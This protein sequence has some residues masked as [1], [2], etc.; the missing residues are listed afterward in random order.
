MSLSTIKQW[1]DLISNNSSRLEKEK[2]IK[3]AL[4][5]E[6]F[7]EKIIYYTYNP[8]LI[9]HT[10]RVNFIKL[11]EDQ[12][13]Q[14]LNN[15]DNIFNVL[16]YLNNKTGASNEDIKLLSYVSSYDNDTV[17]VVRRI[18]NKD[19]RCGAGPKTFE[20]FIFIPSYS[21]MLCEKDLE[22]FVDKIIK[23]DFT[24]CV[25][26]E[27]KD[28]VRNIEQNFKYISRNGKEYPNFNVFNYEIELFRT[29]LNKLYPDYTNNPLDGEVIASISK[30]EDKKTFQKLMTQVRRL[31][32][33]NPSYFRFCIFDIV[34]P[35]LSFIDR[36]KILKD[37]MDSLELQNINL[38]KIEILEH[39]SC[40]HFK[41][42]KDIISYNE[43]VSEQYDWEGLVLK[44]INGQYERKRSREWC[45]VKKFHTL[46]VEVIGAEFGKDGKKYEDILGKLVC[47][48]NG[49][50]FRVGSGFSD[51]ERE[52]FIEEHPNIIEIEYQEL[53]KDGIPRFPTFKRVRDDK[54]EVD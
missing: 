47:I 32:Q 4:N 29:E 2:I 50:E 38:N 11:D 15:I 1:L 36:Y 16:D 45:K 31:N 26:S 8:F 51:E 14:Y 7:F 44:S 53:S 23:N 22:Y 24:Q 52:L 25:L 27:K 37:T 12:K 13:K 33:I 35:Q 17:E 20:K 5:Q 41:N 28:G 43:M 39:Y 42:I 46:D 21:A 18:I 10:T 30:K 6:P 54:N 48:Y 40:S 9:F 34:I 3:N 19:L 49:K